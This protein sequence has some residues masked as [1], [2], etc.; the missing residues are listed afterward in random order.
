MNKNNL[1]FYI[2]RRFNFALIENYFSFVLF[3]YFLDRNRFPPILRVSLCRGYRGLRLPFDLVALS[4]KWQYPWL[5]FRLPA[6]I[7]LSILLPSVSPRV[8]AQENT[9]WQANSSPNYINGNINN[10][11][12]R[13]GEKKKM[14]ITSSYQI[15]YILLLLFFFNK[16]Q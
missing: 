9:I 15:K 2:L 4:T 10:G 12:T 16:M 6:L 1:S 14:L 3:E 5:P 8:F 13:G 7:F 11:E